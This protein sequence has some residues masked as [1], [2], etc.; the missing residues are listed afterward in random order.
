MNYLSGLASNHDPPDF[1]LLSS[2]DYRCEPPVPFL[3]MPLGQTLGVV[4][5]LCNV[6]GDCRAE[7]L[8]VSLP[9]F[10]VQC[11]ASERAAS[12]KARSKVESAGSLLTAWKR[13]Q[14]AHRRESKVKRSPQLSPNVP[15]KYHT[16]SR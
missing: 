16:P 7:A 3:R 8:N 4:G 11:S 6:F 13:W 1:C 14:T 5:G 10:P 15:Y 9:L 2:L 12:G